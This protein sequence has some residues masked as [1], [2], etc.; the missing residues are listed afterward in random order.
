[1]CDPLELFYE[2]HYNTRSSIILFDIPSLVDDIVVPA[3]GNENLFHEKELISAFCQYLYYEAPED[4]NNM[5]MIIDLIKA[6]PDKNTYGVPMM[7]ALFN[8]CKKQ[9]KDKPKRF[10]YNGV[11]TFYDFIE[12]KFDGDWEKLFENLNPIIEYWQRKEWEK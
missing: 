11:D 2:E 8:R 9:Y 12:N 10:E 6:L 5:P 7:K 4:E 3:M 1:M